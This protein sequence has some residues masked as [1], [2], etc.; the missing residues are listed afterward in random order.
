MEVRKGYKQ[1]EVGVIPEDWEDLTFKDICWVNQGLQINISER[2]SMPNKDSK[3]YLT[4]QYLNEGKTVEYIDKY[5]SSVCCNEDDVL[6]TRTGNTGIVI[7]GVNGVFHNNFF[8]INF[9]RTKVDKSFLI[10]YL[11][12]SNTKKI[13]LA[14]AGIS[15]IPDLNHSDFYSIPITLPTKSEQIAIAKTLS[16]A[17]ALINSLEKLIEKKRAIK[18]GAM[19]ELLRPKEGWKVC[20]LSEA[21][22]FLDGQRRP[23]KSNDRKFGEYRYYGASGIIDYIDNYIFD[24]ELILLGE[25]GENILSRNLP[26]AFRVNGKIWV[27]NHAHVL[28]PKEQ[29]NI[30][31]LTIYLESLDYSLLNSG[32]AQP[33]LNKQACLNI[34]VTFPTKS[35]QT[36]I[37]T[38]ISDMDAE[39]E[40]LEEKLSKYK[41]VKQGMMQE[42]LTGRIRLSA[43]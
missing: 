19:Q 25:D 39:I 38:I 34:K 3:V 14:K 13:I 31:Y 12:Q 22:E 33:K 26:L 20:N 23:I 24:D 5:N 16:D 8:K 42:L 9:D 30:G 2:L 7:S 15:T 1:T 32:T 37:D 11:N 6:M 17:D 10:Y 28:K 18:Q 35:E 41:M 27:N 29:F 21:V 40:G 43:D 36:L 4:I